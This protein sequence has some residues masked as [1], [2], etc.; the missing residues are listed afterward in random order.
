[1]AFVGAVGV[2]RG[3]R[4]VRGVEVVVVVRG[5][6]AVTAAACSVVVVVVMILGDEVAAA[7]AVVAEAEDPRG[8]EGMKAWVVEAASRAM[9]ATRRRTVRLLSCMV[10]VVLV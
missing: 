2:L 3:R 8:K 5:G 9:S 1:M 6:A 7:A 4:R 10:V